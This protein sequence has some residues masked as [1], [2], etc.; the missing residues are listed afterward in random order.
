MIPAFTSALS[1]AQPDASQRLTAPS[2][3]VYPPS[4]CGGAGDGR[5]TL[6]RV[7]VMAVD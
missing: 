6:S 5:G 2:P 3:M 1:S 7:D 4:Y